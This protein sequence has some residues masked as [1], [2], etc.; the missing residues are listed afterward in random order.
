[1]QRSEE[2]KVAQAPIKVILGGNEYEI[3]PLVIR[4][5]RV[6]RQ[7]V[8]TALSTIPKHAKATTDDPEKFAEALNAMLVA[9]PDTVIDL[10]FEYA[11]NLDRDEIEG[12]ATDTEVATAFEEVVGLAFPLASSL[13]GAMGNLSR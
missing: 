8:V 13:A 7:K 4:D 9:M 12:V 3:K 6:W 1:M 5:S 11:K 2:E 10:F